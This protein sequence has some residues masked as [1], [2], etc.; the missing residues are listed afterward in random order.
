MKFRNPENGYIEVSQLWLWTLLFGGIYFLVNGLVA[1]LIIW[2]IIGAGLYAALGPPATILMPVVSIAFAGIASN[3]V[4]T[5]YLRKGWVEVTSELSAPL[6]DENGWGT[7]GNRPRQLNETK[8][9]VGK[10]KPCPYLL[11]T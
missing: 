5:S 8:P 11:K 1:P 4:R 7:F 6:P 9:I 10:T 2:V 3:M